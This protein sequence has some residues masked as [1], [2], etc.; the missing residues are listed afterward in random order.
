MKE[1]T[2]TRRTD[3]KRPR[4]EF[5]DADKAFIYKRDRATCAFTGQSLWILDHGASPLHE[6][7]WVDHIRP[8]SRGG[9][10]NRDNGVCASS[11]A[12]YK[13]G[14]NTRDADFWFWHG[15]PTETCLYYAGGALPWLMV[16]L[17]RLAGL[18]ESDWYLNRAFNSVLIAVD[19]INE[20][21]GA[22]RT[23]RYWCKAALSKLEQWRK[24]SENDPP[25]EKRRILLKP[26]GGDQL[27][28]LSLRTCVTLHAVMNVVRKL[29]PYALAN[30]MA[31]S[32]F[33]KALQAKRPDRAKQIIAKAR[34]NRKVSRQLIAWMRRNLEAVGGT[35]IHRKLEE[36]E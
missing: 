5:S 9:S 1:R 26:L 20:P 28:L 19:Q 22:Q 15:Q 23:P 8:S 30:D 35:G 13:K 17:K 31:D 29:A 12:N 34:A 14:N 10:A 16:Q 11:G 3:V 18:C 6:I 33:L 25:L 7:D 24:Y 36:D 21:D 32:R 4:K 27:L 2:S